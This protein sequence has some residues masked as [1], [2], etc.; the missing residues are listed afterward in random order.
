MPI[1]RNKPLPLW[2]EVN[3]MPSDKEKRDA[4]IDEYARLQRIKAAPDRDKE[5]EYQLAIV[6]AKLEGYG[7]ISEDLD[8]H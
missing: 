7:A 8:I 4:L 3:D 5:I 2:E 1:A 6:K